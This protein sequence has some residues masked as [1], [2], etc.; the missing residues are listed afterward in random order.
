MIEIYGAGPVRIRVFL[1][2]PI[3]VTTADGII[4]KYIGMNFTDRR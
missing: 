2:Y 4:K 1:D 3:G